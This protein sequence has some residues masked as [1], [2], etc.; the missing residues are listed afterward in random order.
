[1]KRFAIALLCFLPLFLHA[2]DKSLTV[3]GLKFTLTAPWT[4]AQNTGMMT[5]AI[6]N[7]PVEGGSPMEAKFY[8][9]GGPS[10]GVEANMARW[11]NSFESPPEVKKEELTF[12]D[13]KVYLLSATGTY[14]DGMPGGAK[15]PKADSTLLG[16]IIVTA[17]SSVF[18]KLVGP[19]AAVAKAQPDFKKL[20]SSPFAK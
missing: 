7:Y 11:T 1:M 12:G 10:G 19:K 4:E 15:T 8:D 3:G 5:K 20:V 14:M 16:A 2:E 6:L 17:D 9:F 18:I 13:T